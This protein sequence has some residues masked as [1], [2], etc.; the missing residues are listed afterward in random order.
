MQADLGLRCPHMPEDK[1]S[2]G[3]AHVQLSALFTYR[4]LLVHYCQPSSVMVCAAVESNIRNG[5]EL[6]S[7]KI[8]YKR[9]SFYSTNSNLQPLKPFGL[10]TLYN[11]KPI[12]FFGL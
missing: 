12:S 8:I 10:Q 4:N 9:V 2:H 11:L 6:S 1:L 5:G 7:V 3:A